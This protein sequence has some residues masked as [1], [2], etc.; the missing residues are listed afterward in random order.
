MVWCLVL[1]QEKQI[2]EGK[3]FETNLE[4]YLNDWLM[5]NGVRGLCYAFPD[6]G[7]QIQRIDLL[8]DSDVGNVGIE[9]KSIYEIA[10]SFKT[11]KIELSKL[12]RP[13]KDGVGQ[14]ERQHQFLRETG[15]LG[16][17]AIEFRFSK[18]IYLLPHE[19]V[20]QKLSIGDTILTFSEI[21]KN[22]YRI[23]SPGKLE[24]FLR[25]KCGIA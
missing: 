15:R 1:S 4:T 21:I 23:G 10:N 2:D 8:L 18:E 14:L 25:N 12:N 13:G 19:F 6:G 11:G 22:S 9:C 5:N 20:F 3:V 16:V 7:N 24:L 17:L